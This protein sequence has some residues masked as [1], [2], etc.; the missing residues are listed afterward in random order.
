MNG[1]MLRLRDEDRAMST[2]EYAVGTVAVCALAGLLLKLLTSNTMVD[3]LWRVF[4]KAF[5]LIF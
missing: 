2:A 3:L 5:E 1:L 4:T